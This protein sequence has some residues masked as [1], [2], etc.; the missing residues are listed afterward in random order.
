MPAKSSYREWLKQDWENLIG[1][2]QLDDLQKHALQSRW[3]DQAL[4]MEH[5]AEQNRNL[6]YVLRLITILGGVLIPPLISLFFIHEIFELVHWTTFVISI[7]VAMS[8]AVEQFFHFGERWS[9]YRK[10]AEWLKLRG[11]QFIQLSGPYQRY[12]THTAAYRAFADDVEA[13]IQ[14]D[15]ATYLTEVIHE[16]QEDKDTIIRP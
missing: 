10:T 6:H 1:K 11:W 5:R 16:K 15:V 12:K 9:N 13:I 7:L 4:W 2:L 3:L 14:E 8:S